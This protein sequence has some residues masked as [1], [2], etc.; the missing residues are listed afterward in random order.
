MGKKTSPPSSVIIRPASWQEDNAGLRHIR[1]TVFIHEQSVPVELE[2]DGEDETA[3]HL[4]ALT[5]PDT[6]VGTARMLP[7]GHIGR[8]AVLP[9][10]RTHGVG[11]AMMEQLLEEAKRLGHREVFLDAQ[12]DALGFYERLGFTAEGPVFMDAGIPHRHMRLR[13]A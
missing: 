1:E 12:L 11:T 4:L 6:P 3:L 7:D 9:R 13:I 10:W 2:W 5:A 8:V